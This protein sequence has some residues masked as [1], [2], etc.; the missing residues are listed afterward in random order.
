MKVT[1]GM[2]ML[3]H[4][5]NPPLHLLGFLSLASKSRRDGPSIPCM[6]QEEDQ[7]FV[8]PG[9]TCEETRTILSSAGRTGANRHRVSAVVRPKMSKA[10][11]GLPGG[12]LANG[13]QKPQSLG[14]RQIGGLRGGSGKCTWMK[15]DAESGSVHVPISAS[16]RADFSI[17]RYPH[18]EQC[19]SRSQGR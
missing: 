8:G 9:N 7:K 2:V 6:E 17:A 18:A 4:D 1:S 15:N 16:R 5:K 13:I 3:C 10:E 12:C 14:G 11:V 19:A